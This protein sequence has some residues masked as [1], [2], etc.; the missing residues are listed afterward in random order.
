[1]APG[2]SISQVPGAPGKPGA[3][4]LIPSSNTRSEL[5]GRAGGPKNAGS[6]LHAFVHSTNTCK[7]HATSCPATSRH[8]EVY[9]RHTVQT[10]TFHQ[11]YP[12]A[13]MGTHTGPPDDPLLSK[14]GLSTCA[15]G[16]TPP[17]HVSS[18]CIISLLPHYLSH[19]PTD[20][21]HW[22]VNMLTWS[23]ALESLT[24]SLL[25]FPEKHLE[26][27]VHAVC[28]TL[29]PPFSLEPTPLGLLSPSLL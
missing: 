6:C 10:S 21:S 9:W 7:G 27:L 28:S 5:K 25:L 12:P 17:S 18:P 29:F 24:H 22:H 3:S 14:A 20:W 13:C 2:A 8:R 11:M 26:R 1:M 16:C 4:P 15:L 23:P 19:V